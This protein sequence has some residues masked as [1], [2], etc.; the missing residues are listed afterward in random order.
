MI[1]RFFLVLFLSGNLWAKNSFDDYYRL[2]S[3]AEQLEARYTELGIH[4]KQRTDLS[5]E[6]KKKMKAEYDE[7]VDRFIEVSKEMK[8]L[9]EVLTVEAWSHKL[10]KMQKINQSFKGDVVNNR[11]CDQ[12]G[13]Y[14]YFINNDSFEKWNQ[15]NGSSDKK[16]EYYSRKDP[17]IASCLNRKTDGNSIKVS[18]TYRKICN[19]WIGPIGTSY[20]YKLE[21]KM[22]RWLFQRKF[23]LITVESQREKRKPLSCC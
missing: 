11:I 1:L 14:Q 13:E 7:V 17:Y 2:E 21:K 4:W 10:N 8:K 6:T 9:E 20:N 22:V 12:Q 3:E 23:L 19:R 5:A 16:I 18:G 15:K